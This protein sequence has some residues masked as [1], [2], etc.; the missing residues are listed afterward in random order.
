V[1]RCVGGGIADV[2]MQVRHFHLVVEPPNIGEWAFAEG[3]EIHH[4][5]RR[6]CLWEGYYNNSI[7]IV[8]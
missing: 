3:A 7:F 2:L 5:S 8:F 4:P 1:K 6:V